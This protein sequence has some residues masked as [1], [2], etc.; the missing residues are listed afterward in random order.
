MRYN[1]KHW[2]NDKINDADYL[3]WIRHTEKKEKFPSVIYITPEIAFIG[4]TE[5]EL[6]KDKIPYKKLNFLCW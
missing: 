3:S 4:K 1:L 5:E 2:Y 6:K